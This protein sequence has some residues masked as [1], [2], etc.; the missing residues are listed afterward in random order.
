MNKGF[1]SLSKKQVMPV[2]VGL[3]GG[4]ASGKSTC[5]SHLSS[6]YSNTIT[7]IDCDRINHQLLNNHSSYLYKQICRH[8]G[9]VIINKDHSINRLA[10]GRIIFNDPT[11]RKILNKI[12]HQAILFRMI[13]LLLYHMITGKR[14]IV[15]DIP[16]L[17]EL[18]LQYYLPM[19]LLV[20]A[21]PDIQLQRLLKRNPELS[22]ED[23]QSRL[24]SQMDMELKK[25]YATLVIDNSSTDTRLREQLDE[26]VT[27]SLLG[28]NVVVHVIQWSLL[29]VPCSIVYVGC[30]IYDRLAMHL[31]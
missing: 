25:Q 24:D 1:L 7:I 9:Q 11:Q 14:V 21:P 28:Q 22:V 12:S 6:H 15:L 30:W 2:V 23:A 19:T 31:F 18:K 10:L 3:S 17:F 4:I 27:T 16:L 8:F 26:L 20:Y 5:A 13:Q 29:V